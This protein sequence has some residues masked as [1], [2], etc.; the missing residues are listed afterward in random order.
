MT[1]RI[2]L[3]R[4]K[5]HFLAQCFVVTEVLLRGKTCVMGH[6]GNLHSTVY[7]HS[8]LYSQ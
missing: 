2:H 7:T 3:A 6:D 5:G 1:A 4:Q 8:T